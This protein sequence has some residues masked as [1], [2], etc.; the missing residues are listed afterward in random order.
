MATIETIEDGV[1]YLM[2]DAK[3]RQYDIQPGV[4]YQNAETGKRVRIRATFQGCEVFI[5]DIRVTTVPTV[6]QARTKVLEFLQPQRSSFPRDPRV[7][8][9]TMRTV[10]SVLEC[11][12]LLDDQPTG[13]VIVL[14]AG[15][16]YYLTSR[17]S[18][19]RSP[20]STRLV[21]YKL[22]QANALAG[23]AQ[24]KQYEPED[25]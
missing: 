13:L 21:V 9:T 20:A 11:G 16:Q 8:F 6:L 7:S 15:G 23:N 19:T 3:V 17:G 5:N 4:V 25:R 22:A 12:V 24:P 10:G 2:P 14:D 1:I 18:S